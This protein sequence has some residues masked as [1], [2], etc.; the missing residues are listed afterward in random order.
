[1]PFYQGN[2]RVKVHLGSHAFSTN[3]PDLIVGNFVLDFGL[4]VNLEIESKY[5]IRSV[6]KTTAF[7]TATLVSKNTIA[8]IPSMVLTGYDVI[9]AKTDSGVLIYIRI[10]PANNVMYEENFVTAGDGWT[11]TSSTTLAIQQKTPG[12]NDIYGHDTAYTNTSNT[13]SNGTA[14]KATVNGANTSISTFTFTG[15]GLELMGECG[16]NTGV[17]FVRVTEGSKNTKA[18]GTHKDKVYIVDTYFNGKLTD[19]S[20]ENPI[21]VGTLCQIPVIHDL[22]LHYGT[23]NVN[24]MG[25]YVKNSGALQGVASTV[26]VCGTEEAAESELS[27]VLNE[28]GLE[29]QDVEIEYISMNEVLGGSD[30]GVAIY[31]DQVYDAAA[32]ANNGLDVYID[33]V[34][35]Y[36]TL[37]AEPA[38]YTEQGGKVCIYQRITTKKFIR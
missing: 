16:Q 24:V 36:N 14:L 37:E 21:A 11:K 1:M 31:A 25:Y 18:D 10:Y 3:V 23:H 30:E 12:A 4:P 6:E 32:T 2:H 34:R 28:L 5:S 9:K 13:Y 17:M 8:Y 33:G 35:V 38:A 15:D 22:D 26:A 29:P 20:S 19:G 27:V 7:G